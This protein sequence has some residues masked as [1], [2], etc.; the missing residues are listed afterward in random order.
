MAK[1]GKKSQK[2]Y[3]P[4]SCRASTFITEN[5]QCRGCR[6]NRNKEHMCAELIK[7]TMNANDLDIINKGNLIIKHLLWIHFF[8]QLL[9]IKNNAWVTVNNDIFWS[10]VGWFAN[11]IHEWRSQDWKSLANH[12][13]NIRSPHEYSITSRISI[14]HFAIVARDGIFWLNIVTS[15]QLICDVTRTRG[16]GIVTSYSSIVLARANWRKGDL[17]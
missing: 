2:V 13:T 12:L 3:G 14:A 5:N 10:R 11:D 1:G 7:I 9:D 8:Y 4:H 6:C 17:N 16:T 15:S